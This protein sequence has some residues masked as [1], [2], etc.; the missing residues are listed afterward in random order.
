M[1]R[2]CWIL[3]SGLALAAATAGSALA[4]SCPTRPA[5]APA[6]DSRTYRHP[7]L[8]IAFDIPANYRAM[9]LASGRVAFYD[10]ATFEQVQCAVRNG[11]AVRAQPAAT[12][13]L[14]FVGP[15]AESDLLALT[16]RA[17]PWL[18]LYQPTY[19]AIAANQVPAV[20]YQYVHE[21]YGNPVSGL[22]FRSPNQQWL[23]TL[24]GSPGNAIS[25][26]ALTTLQAESAP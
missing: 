3:L 17:R 2:A 10:P 21:I 19:R 22:S 1:I 5:A 23:I 4:Q 13:D 18:V 6:A 16:Q 9:G 20:A 25:T 12:L 7:S 8:D 11:L 24:E 26:L 14:N 15:L